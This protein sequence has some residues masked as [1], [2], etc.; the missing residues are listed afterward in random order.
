MFKQHWIKFL[1]VLQIIFQNGFQNIGVDSNIAMYS[2]VTRPDHF[3]QAVWELGENDFWFFKNGK[4]ILEL[5]GQ[6]QAFVGDHVGG[7]ANRRLNGPLQIQ[8]KNILNV[9]VR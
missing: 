8:D 7:E 6:S 2:D 1:K 9:H 4:V 3:L 5:S